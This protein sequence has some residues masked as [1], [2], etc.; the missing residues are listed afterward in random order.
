VDGGNDTIYGDAI[1]RSLDDGDHD[2]VRFDGEFEQFKLSVKA[3]ESGRRYIEVKDLLQGDLGLGINK[4]YDIENISFS[5][6]WM[7]VGVRYDYFENGNGTKG[8]H[9]NGSE[10]DDDIEGTVDGDSINGGL[11]NDI[12]R[13][14]DGADYFDGGFGNDIIYGGEEGLNPW[15]H[16]DVDVFNLNGSKADYTIRHF[17]SSGLETNSYQLDGYMEVSRTIGVTTETD[18]LYGIERIRF[19]GSELNFV[20]ANGFED[21]KW[22]WKG[23]DDEDIKKADSSNRDERIYGNA[24]SDTLMGGLGSDDLIGG[25]GDD[26]LYGNNSDGDADKDEIGLDN[27]DTAIFADTFADVVISKV[28]SATYKIETSNEGTDTLYD[29]EVLQFADRSERLVKEKAGRDLN[30]DGVV[31][32]EIIY[33]TFEDDDFD[34]S[35]D[36]LLATTIYGG[37]GNDNVNFNSS[38][39]LR[40]YDNL[41][42]NTYTASGDSKNDILFVNDTIESWTTKSDQTYNNVTFEDMIESSVTGSKIY[43]QGFERI[44]FEDSVIN[45]KKTE[46]FFDV[47]DDGKID[48]TFVSGADTGEIG[49]ELDYSAHSNAVNLN[50]NGGDDLITGSAFDDVIRGGLGNDTV[51]G[52]LGSDVFILDVNKSDAVV[53]SDQGT[54]TITHSGGEV[55][56]LSGIEAIQFNDGKERLTILQEDIREYVYGEGFVTTQKIIGNN[57]DNIFIA[58][59]RNKIITTGAGKDTIK[60]DVS[61]TYSLKISDFDAEKDTFLFDT[62]SEIEITGFT[63]LQNGDGEITLSSEAEIIVNDSYGYQKVS[64]NTLDYFLFDDDSYSGS[65]TIS[66]ASLSRIIVS[67]SNSEELS[68]LQENTTT[69]PTHTILNIGT[70]TVQIDG[71]TGSVTLGDILELI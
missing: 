41:G 29:I 35:V 21:G 19:D 57:F 38:E 37:A 25:A 49:S 36:P 13:G 8:T 7:S 31:D 2:T 40:I 6:K 33:G 14:G 46:E 26:I 54:F 10:F 20:S 63:T 32:L 5:N 24:G 45:L 12:L 17:N 43:L 70:G 11:G 18:T 44:T 42:V 71:I 16:K 47:D 30:R 1:D 68:W 9:I 69:T 28:S 52:G 67:A 39:S 64:S 27:V 22:V 23:T 3:E 4:L 62:A 56:S 48:V 61:D 50:G 66:D 55:D 58:E 59:D 34:V 60:V 15:G 65:L 51:L 53:E